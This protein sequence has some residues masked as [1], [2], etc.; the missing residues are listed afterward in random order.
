MGEEQRM[1]ELAA[2]QI[3]KP[4]DD[5]AF[6]RCNEILWRCILNDDSAQLF[7]RRG[8]KQHGVD[9]VG[10]RNGQLDR[11]VGIQC[12][13]KGDGKALEENEVRDEVT[14]ALT[15]TP[16]LSE[17]IIVTTALDDA[18]LQALALE[19]SI[20]VSKDRER[21][22]RVQI[23]G[24]GR[25]EREIRRHPKAMDAFG[26][27]HTSHITRVEKRISSIPGD[28]RAV[29]APELDAIRN[30]L[31]EIKAFTNDKAVQ[32]EHDRQIDQYALLI[33]N[34]P[35]TALTLLNGLLNALGSGTIGRTK[36]RVIANIAICQ[37]ELGDED[38][39]ARGFISAGDYD[40]GNPRASACK[41]FGLLL[42]K[43]WE[44]VRSFAE[45]RLRSDPG[46]AG[47]AACYIHSLIQDD[48]ITDP[49]DHVSTAVRGTEEVTE[50]HIRWLMER[51]EPGAWWET[52]VNGHKAHPD[53]GRMQEMRACALLDQAIEHDV[54]SKRG[55]LSE[56]V[57]SQVQQSIEIFQRQWKEV[58]ERSGCMRTDA[59]SVP[60][61]LMVAYRLLGESEEAIRV[62]T[63]ARIRFPAEVEIR[64]HLALSM[65]EAGKTDDVLELISGIPVNPQIV[66]IRYNVAIANEDWSEILSLT[67]ECLEALPKTERPLARAI[68]AVARV[69]VAGA[70]D[71]RSILEGEQESFVDH[72]RASVT[73]AECARRHGFDDLAKHYVHAAGV[74]LRQGDNGFAS[75]RAVAYE[76]MAQSNPSSAV[77]ALIDQVDLD[78]DSTELR[79]L[80]HAL[81]A[82]YPI[83]Q[84]AVRFF[85][86]ISS[87]VRS[88]PTFQILEGALHASTGLPHDAIQP[89]S[90]ALKQD[91]SIEN[92]MYLVNAH[93]RAGNS[94]A[95]V[96]LLQADGVDTLPG[97]ASSRMDLCG[98]LLDL[99][100]T[101]RALD[102]AYITLVD[103]LDESTIVRRFLELVLSRREHSGGHAAEEQDRIVRT[104]SWVRL[105]QD[106]RNFEALIGDSTDRPWGHK[107]DLSND[108]V[109]KAIGCKQGDHFEHTHPVTGATETW[110]IEETSPR[111]L[112]AFHHL[113]SVFNQ[114]FPDAVG[115]ATMSTGDGDVETA[116]D[117][118]RRKSQVDRAHADL[119]LVENLPLAFVGAKEPGGGITF[120]QYI[121]SIGKDVRVCRGTVAELADALRL[122][123]R[124]SD[125]GVVLDA[126]TAWHIAELGIFDV[127]VDRLGCVALPASELNCLKS[128][129]RY[130]EHFGDKEEMRIGYHNEQ[131]IRQV[132]T[133]EQQAE[134]LNRLKSRISV[135]SRECVT[136]P[137]IIPDTVSRIGDEL[138]R[139]P[140]GESLAPGIL[141]G[142][143]RLLLSEDMM[144]RQLSSKGFG[145]R[146]VWLQAVALS[147]LRAESM[148]L[149]LYVD[150]AVHLA[151]HRHGIV[152]LD[153]CVIHAAYERDEGD[154]L[155]RL[156]AL[157]NYVGNEHAD[158]SSHTMIVS[159]FVNLIWDERAVLSSK[160]RRA[161]DVMFAALLSRERGG[162]EARWVAKCHRRLSEAPRLYLLDWCEA[163]SVAVGKLHS[164]RRR[165]RD[166]KSERR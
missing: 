32:T 95:I 158:P 105:T 121:A 72:T 31:S 149:D 146:G 115:F 65:A 35:K 25:L 150:V 131:Y 63:E 29:L 20:S 112:R 119:Y 155:A 129:V 100:Y 117:L 82:D 88:L 30:D 152:M 161:T 138:I 73:L 132:V 49:L 122:I 101:E 137:L 40:P 67:S 160:V 78:H 51:G 103:H 156:R 22:L 2:T 126:L 21:D 110:T 70:V 43:D 17:F 42:Q 133:V 139:T 55:S 7:G 92:L 83:R 124:H 89:F 159:E 37:L 11:I 141:A 57:R 28:T 154:E 41:A 134:R 130:Y 90:A 163:N 164:S 59:I 4:S 109:T 10:H 5:T 36:F 145:T 157:S 153:A 58:R 24:W 71:R 99:G 166:R 46:N 143:D 93:M 111:W 94:E 147:A 127:V 44:S 52:A 140:A 56:A 64:E 123:A 14:K 79:L 106:R 162:E 33:R 142:E 39:A 45:A 19:L 128:M 66:V 53:S 86:D 85:K 136:E 50:A 15:F 84:R 120:A 165:T 61:N 9:I 6:E 102:L 68:A 62:G 75:R 144:L 97:S 125:S 116:L 135:I 74:A 104:G 12:K 23:L 1:S 87:E 26:P 107:C 77:D 18:K 114:R 60:I 98:A 47:L 16:P 54:G 8:Q 76:A 69:E 148:S 48:S 91:P 81:V 80:A 27:H 3:S 96:P 13:L 151:K 118:V 113:S 38:A 108:F 34:D